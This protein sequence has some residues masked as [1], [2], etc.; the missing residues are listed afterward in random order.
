MPIP[1]PFGLGHIGTSEDVGN[2]ANRQELARKQQE[3]ADVAAVAQRLSLM[4]D[5][6][7]RIIA[8]LPR[9][10]R[11]PGMA[12]AKMI[13]EAVSG[14]Q[15]RQRVRG[16]DLNSLLT[17]QVQ[18][19]GVPGT[20]ARESPEQGMSLLGTPGT[21]ATTRTVP[22]TLSER[23]VGAQPMEALHPSLKGLTQHLVGAGGVEAQQA[24]AAARRDAAQTGR[25]SKF[26]DED[27][28]VWLIDSRTATVKPA[29]GLPGQMLQA[30]PDVTGPQLDYM[31]AKGNPVAQRAVARRA[32]QDMN[33]KTSTP[34]ATVSAGEGLTTNLLPAYEGGKGYVGGGA[35]APPPP[36]APAAPAPPVAAP[37]AAPPTELN[38]A[39][40]LAIMQTP[41]GEAGFRAASPGEQQDRVRN[42]MLQIATGRAPQTGFVGLDPHAVPVEI[43][44]GVGSAPPPSAA[45]APAPAPVSSGLPPGT[46]TI[47]GAPRPMDQNRADTIMA[48][49]SVHPPGLVAEAQRFTAQRQ[50]RAIEA[51]EAASGVTEKRQERL[52]EKRT[53][54]QVARAKTILHQ[55]PLG[56]SRFA[57]RVIDTKK[58]ELVGQG[59][60]GELLDAQQRQPG[61]FAVVSKA[62][63]EVYPRIQ[64]MDAE[65]R[66]MEGALK[67]LLSGG[68]FGAYANWLK[69]GRVGD[70]NPLLSEAQRVAKGRL[71]QLLADFPNTFN[72][73]INMA[74]ARQAQQQIN[75]LRGALDRGNLPQALESLH[76]M[77]RRIVDMKKAIT[78]SAAPLTDDLLLG[79]AGAAG[80]EAGS[81]PAPSGRDPRIRVLP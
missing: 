47:R 62:V 75:L 58:N 50:G 34:P 3:Q 44:P 52:L 73:I 46:I 4:G 51:A 1:L 32:Q 26:V 21:P 41:G 7:A 79:E 16:L 11:Q 45:A 27:G 55:T 69:T 81:A 23:V 76:T 72:R 70:Y 2:L 66:E 78:Q 29:E 74:G 18:V 42:A 53:E 65:A 14:A 10:A 43:P 38:Q 71:D 30:I 12:A 17:R 80:T 28:R 61:R 49:P 33:L 36:V 60:V 68:A 15:E 22:T 35:P 25:W 9:T 63:A 19:P 48:N 37:T 67:T 39:L 59:T 24:E 13:Q 54:E 20:P 6:D 77:E 56:A 40:R 57:D 8:D 31:A 64:V 5:D